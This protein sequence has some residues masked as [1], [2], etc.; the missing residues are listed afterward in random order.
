MPEGTVGAA[1]VV[2][3]ARRI[4]L[5]ALA[6]VVWLA[7]FAVL[8]RQR[9]WTQFAVAGV[10]LA[11]LALVADPGT[12]ALLRPTRA[13]AAIG[14]GAGLFMV[15]LT[16]L[17]FA[18]ATALAPELREATAW[19]F[20]LA[21][22]DGSSDGVRAALIVL[23][24]A[25]EEVTFRGALLDHAARPQLS[26]AHRD[27]ALRPLSRRE[28]VRLGVCSAAYAAS[29]LTLGSALLC[30]CAFV[31]GLAWAALRVAS[32]SL[33]PAVVAHAVWDLGVLI[34]WPL[35]SVGG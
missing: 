21:H 29:M 30:A 23:I 33:V 24:A 16:H 10:S 27:R 32:R 28:V 20:R 4:A 31:C 9:T 1:P 19:L 7:S 35:I 22:A 26:A 8:L 14:L 13:G 18:A 25:C 17:L 11:A 15:A 12:R 6:S 2:T 5:F 3:D 34:V